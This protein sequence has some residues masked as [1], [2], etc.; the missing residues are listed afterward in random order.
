ML[1]LDSA[2]LFLLFLIYSCIGYICEVIYC[3]CLVRRFVDRGF[4]RG[5]ICPI[6]GFGSVLL[7]MSTKKVYKKPLLKFLIATIAFTLFEYMVSFALEM[8]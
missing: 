4:L 7:L 1:G 3:S 6:Y 2:R 5:P 8:L